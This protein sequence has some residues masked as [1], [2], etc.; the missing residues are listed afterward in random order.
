MTMLMVPHPEPHKDWTWENK[1]K[2]CY[3]CGRTFN[4]PERIAIST[5]LTGCYC[6]DCMKAIQESAE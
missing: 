6:F 1:G 5:N 2:L 3:V 4:K